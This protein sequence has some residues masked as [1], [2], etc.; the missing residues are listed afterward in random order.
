MM[1]LYPQTS[2][3]MLLD[4]EREHVYDDISLFIRSLQLPSY[5]EEAAS[6]LANWTAAYDAHP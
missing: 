3:G 2:H 1:K 4:Q 6:G 5:K